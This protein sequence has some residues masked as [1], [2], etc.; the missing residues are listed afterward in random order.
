LDLT[1]VSCY[2][3]LYKSGEALFGWRWVMSDVEYR[4]VQSATAF[5][6]N[7]KQNV[8]RVVAITIGLVITMVWNGL[9]IFEAGRL[10]H[11]W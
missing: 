5:P 1:E 10:V 2:V 11:L 3:I 6:L 4:E 7:I 9:L 8:I